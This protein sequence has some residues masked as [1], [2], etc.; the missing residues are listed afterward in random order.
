MEDLVSAPAGLDLVVSVLEGLDSV[1]EGLDSVRAV[2]GVLAPADHGARVSSEVQDSSEVRGSSA[3]SL[4][5]CAIWL[6]PG[7]YLICSQVSIT[8][9]SF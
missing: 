1:L 2:R 3:A 9:T 4:M 7:D 5:G 6:L 8:I